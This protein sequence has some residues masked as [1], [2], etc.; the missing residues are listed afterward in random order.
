MSGRFSLQPPYVVATLPQPID[1]SN[2]CYVVGEVL[3]RQNGSRKRK[4]SELAIGIHGE[5]VNLYD[6]PSSRL[7]TSY[8]V[9]PQSTFTCAPCSTRI[10]ISKTVAERRTYVATKTP[11]SCVTLFR[12]VSPR[13]GTSTSSAVNCKLDQPA[14]DIVYLGT[15]TT[16]RTSDATAS[17]DLLV[18]KEDGEIL[19]LD[20]ETLEKKWVS[21]ATALYLDRESESPRDAKV[22]F[23][24]LTNAFTASQGILKGRQD[25]MA[26]FSEEVTQDGFNPDILVLVTSAALAEDTSSATLQIFTLPRR[27]TSSSLKQ[28]VDCLLTAKLTEGR[29]SAATKRSY[30]LH[31]STGTLQEL[32]GNKLSSYDLSQTLPKVQSV[33]SIP[34]ATSFLRISNASTMIATHSTVGV[35]NPKFDSV[36]ATVSLDSMDTKAGSK[37][38]RVSD[39]SDDSSKPDYNL[40]AYFPRTGTTVGIYGKE[41]VAVQIDSH[42]D[43]KSATSGLLIDSLGRAIRQKRKG[44]EW[45]EKT[46]RLDGLTTFGSYLPGS[47]G[48]GDPSLSEDFA[49]TDKFVS[50]RDVEGFEGVMVSKLGLNTSNVSA[51]TTVK[52]SVGSAKTFVDRRWVSY[53]IK[54]IFSWSKDG[55]ESYQL[56]IEFYPPKTFAWLLETGNLTVANIEV[57]LRDEVRASPE[58]HI[59][60]GQ[61]VRAIVE[62]DPEL[63]LL[64][65]L[66]DSNYMCAEDLL[67]AIRRLMESLELIGNASTAQNVLTNDEGQALTDG[68]VEDEL[69]Q[70]EA[71]AEEDLRLAEYQLGP[72]SGVRAQALSVALAKLY[73]APSTTIVQALQTTLTGQEV[74]SLIY[75][76]RFELARGSWTSRYLDVGLL[77]SPDEEAEVL[78]STILLITSLLNNCIDAI[79]AGGWLAGDARL[80]NGDF[81]ES[82]DLIRSLKLEVSAALEGIEEASYLKGLMSEFIR[83]GDAVQKALPKAAKSNGEE[84]NYAGKKRKIAPVI[85]PLSEQNVPVLP[86]GLKVEQQ[87]SRLRVAAGGEVQRRTARDIGR[88]KSKKVGKYSLERITI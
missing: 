6:I 15:V 74:V 50:E 3:G 69:E 14:A 54:K 38:R 20:G 79:G 63:E 17:T 34:S 33:M 31:A 26:T 27:L 85:V 80:I 41:L 73:A 46:L 11:Q 1:H 78:N 8:A 87:I 82:E 9:P 18:I 39:P 66:L 13:S 81:Y 64:L 58:Q 30:A 35:Y 84:D 70:L 12:D 49:A 45:T 62:V 37:R 29:A 22:E 77:D 40:V 55:T 43:D 7:I 61:L 83:Y 68:N 72:G 52:G 57:A 65:A 24:H 2:G 51:K 76:L 71:E 10:R 4:R 21:P 19:C 88:L 28:S 16:T 23:A 86:L 53:A 67:H 59:P 60:H 44:S 25:V 56:S 47:I 42:H 32:S 5:G 48:G 75:L 36:L